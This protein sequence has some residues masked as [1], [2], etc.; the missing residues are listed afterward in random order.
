MMDDGGAIRHQSSEDFLFTSQFGGC[1]AIYAYTENGMFALYHLRSTQDA[2]AI[3]VA[4]AKDSN[5]PYR[6]WVES[7]KIQAKGEKIHFQMGTLWY[8]GKSQDLMQTHPEL[9][10]ERYLKKLCK[11]YGIEDYDITLMNMIEVKSVAVD[12]NGMVFFTANS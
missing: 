9:G 7:L 2:K 6:Q 12:A 1:T 3:A 10:M 11:V 4:D 8:P 5:Q